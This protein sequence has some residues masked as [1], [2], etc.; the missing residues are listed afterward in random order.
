ML[1]LKAFHIIAMVAWFAGL[2]YLPRLFVYHCQTE[3]VVGLE[4][5]KTMERRLYYGIMW[6][7]GIFTT[8]L[9]VSLLLY[10]PQY[11]VHAGWMHAKLMLVILLWVYHFICGKYRKQFLTRSCPHS[12]HYFRMFNEIPTIFLVLIVLLVVVKPF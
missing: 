5:F 6:P 12:S 9:G 1:Y 11:Y 2:F 10:N 7:A 8:V 3:D 4:R